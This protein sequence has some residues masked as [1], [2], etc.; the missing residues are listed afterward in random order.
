L[1]T[2][3]E[4]LSLLEKIPQWKKLMEMPS[5][6][7]ALEKRIAVLEKGIAGGADVCPRCTKT[8]FRLISSRPHPVFG[9]MGT[10][11]RL[12]R[13]GQCGFEETKTVNL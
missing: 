10:K 1:S 5:K 11:E 6:L 7:E 8:D 12:Y 3:S 13:C 4:I 2:V 9:D